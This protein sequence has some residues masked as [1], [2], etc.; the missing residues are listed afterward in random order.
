MGVNKD[1]VLRD[2]LEPS[3]SGYRFGVALNIDRKEE[4]VYLVSS[5]KKRTYNSYTVDFSQQ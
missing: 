1:K 4:K 2:A 3:R 5:M